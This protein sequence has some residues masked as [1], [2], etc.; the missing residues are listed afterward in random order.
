MQVTF[1]PNLFTFCHDLRELINFDFRV[2]IELR[3]TATN[4]QRFI[5]YVRRL[6]Q[7][8]TFHNTIGDRMIPCQRPIMLKNALELS[9]LVQSESV[10]WN[11]EESIQRYMATLQDAVSK[12]AHDNTFLYGQHEEV[13][14]VVMRLMNVDLQR[15]AQVWKDE[16]RHLREIF[17]AL[18]TK[19]YQN[20]HGF[21]LH[22]DHQLYKV[23]E[24]QY[25]AG[26][27]DLNNRLPDIY[28]DIVFRQQELQFRPPMEEIRS[29]YF[30]QLRRFLERPLG[31]R[32]LSDQ[33][34]N[35]FKIMVKRSVSNI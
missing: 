10:A 33:S 12:L 14:R 34:N 35:I 11:D 3:D 17:T 29:K 26:L 1:K 30:N 5:G 32:G 9:R 4:A 19:S 23:L 27:S 20:L 28:L 6:Q 2:P 24:H 8:A 13:K 18:E 25:M 31:F 22:W 16:M 7:I 21:K 15:Q